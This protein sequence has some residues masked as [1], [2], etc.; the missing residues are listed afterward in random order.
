MRQYC[1]IKGSDTDTIKK[2]RQDYIKNSFYN[3]PVLS[4]YNKN[5]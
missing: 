4:L 3:N 5:T 2:P 1:Q